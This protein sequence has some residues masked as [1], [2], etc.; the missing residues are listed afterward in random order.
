[1]HSRGPNNGSVTGL[2]AVV[3]TER[4]KLQRN[5]HGMAASLRSVCEVYNFAGASRD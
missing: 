1:V 2:P 3:L 5:L 4:L